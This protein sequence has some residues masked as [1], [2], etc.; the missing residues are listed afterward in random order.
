MFNVLLSGLNFLKIR[1]CYWMLVANTALPRQYTYLDAFQFFKLDVFSIEI[2]VF[3]FPQA[4]FSLSCVSI[5]VN[6]TIQM[7]SLNQNPVILDCFIFLIVYNQQILQILL[8]KYF[9][10]LSLFFLLPTSFINSNHIVRCR[11]IAILS[12]L[13][14]CFLPMFATVYRIYGILLFIKDKSHAPD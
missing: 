7:V 1:N 10:I 2:T 14:S 9:L 5:L 11:I 13:K 3:L 12:K 6:G 4:F 8:P